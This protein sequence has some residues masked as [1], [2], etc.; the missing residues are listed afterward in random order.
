M[1]ANIAMKPCQ[2]KRSSISKINSGSPSTSQSNLAK[3]AELKTNKSILNQNTNIL[4][5]NF[6]INLDEKSETQTS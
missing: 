4:I 1:C 5:K 3:T 6:E 2:S